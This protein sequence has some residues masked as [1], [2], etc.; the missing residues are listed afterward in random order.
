MQQSVDPR[1]DC[2]ALGYRRQVSRRS[3]HLSQA[4][5]D[6]VVAHSAQRDDVLTEL[7]AET[8]SRFGADDAGMQ[9]GP[10]QGIFMTLLAK[11][12]GAASAV[13]VGSFTGYSAICIA[14]GLAEGGRLLCCDVSEEWTSLAREY[15][16]RAGVADQIELRLGPAA[17]TLRALPE[18]TSFDYA[19]IDADKTGYVEYW[20]L[21]VPMIRPG[22]LVLVDNTLSHGRVVDLRIQDDTVQGIRRFNAHAHADRRVELVLL[23]IGDGLTMARKL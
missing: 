7:A 20:D 17:Q 19:F 18:G 10:E 15:W 9:I 4:L 21:I 11:L 14:R 23:P 16:K 12:T 22:G 5:H 3:E 8:V 6:Y 13:E 2:S 1:P